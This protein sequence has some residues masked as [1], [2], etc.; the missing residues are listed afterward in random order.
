MILLSRRHHTRSRAG[1]EIVGAVLPTFAT[2]R[3]Q[4]RHAYSV[5]TARQS[6]G[7]SAVALGFLVALVQRQWAVLQAYQWQLAPGWAVLAL[8]GLELTWLFELD[9]WRMILRSL[10]GPLPYRRAAPIWFLSNII[11]YIPGN[12]WQFLGMAELAAEEGVPRMATFTSIVLHQAISTAAG[13]VLASL[14]FAFAGAGAWFA[15]LRPF[16]LLTPLGLLL[17]QPRILERFLNWA[18]A[19]LRRPALRVTLTWGQVWVLL[20]R[21]LARLAGDGPELRGAGARGDAVSAGRGALPGRIVGR[22]VCDRLPEPADPVGPGRARGDPGAA[23]DRGL[24][25]AA[26]HGHR[27]RGAALD[28]V[29]RTARRRGGVGVLAQTKAVRQTAGR[30][31]SS[32]TTRPHPSRSVPAGLHPRN[33]C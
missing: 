6:G 22:G 19:K 13:I 18:M 7:V 3:L 24:R 16:L 2:F 1:A 11:R 23:V 17:L 30:A 5:E 27:D 29:G 26:A 32:R 10:G 21:Y 12:I 14:Y 20:L 4:W 31:V 28:G 15:W 8:V 9:T 33:R 25:R